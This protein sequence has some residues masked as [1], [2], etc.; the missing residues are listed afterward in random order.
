MADNIQCWVETKEVLVTKNI[1]LYYKPHYTLNKK[2]M[3]P[4]EFWQLHLLQIIQ[5]TY[6]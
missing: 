4:V 6:P 1:T 2:L 5:H 3:L